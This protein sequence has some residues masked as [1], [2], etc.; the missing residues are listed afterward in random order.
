MTARKPPPPMA[1]PAAVPLSPRARQLDAAIAGLD[2][3]L[4]KLASSAAQLAATSTRA[5]HRTAALD[6]AARVSRAAAALHRARE[7]ASA[8]GLLP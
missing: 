3:D 2:R 8:E 5:S 1:K 4:G 7:R 6:L